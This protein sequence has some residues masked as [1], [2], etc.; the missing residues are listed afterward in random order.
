METNKIYNIDC[1]DAFKQ[2]NKNEVDYIFTSPPY[3]RA[4][5]DKY[6]H[7]NDNRNDYF[8]FLDNVVGECLRVSK[9]HVFFNIMQTYYNKIDVFKL[10]GKYADKIIDIFIWEKSNPLPAQGKNITNAYEFFIIFG[11]TKLESNNTYT[12]NIIT[13]SVNNNTDKC[14]HAVMNSVV[15]DWFVTN[16]TK[17]GE[18]VLDPFMGLGTTAISC[19]K[20][21]RNFIGFEINKEY[22]DICVD[23]IKTYTRK[24]KLF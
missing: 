22:F 9:K 19:V 23:N 18:T 17:K 12:K 14:H 21:D 2:M 11:K 7:F 10:I 24:R 6:E 13:T 3:N 20:T 16:F 15:S 5:N 4:R 8:E 1:I